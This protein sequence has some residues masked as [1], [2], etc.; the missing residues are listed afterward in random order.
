MPRRGWRGRGW[1]ELHPRRPPPGVPP[2]RCPERPAQV[3]AVPAGQERQQAKGP[4][5]ALALQD[6]DAAEVDRGWCHELQPAGSQTQLHL[7]DTLLEAKM[8]IE[9]WGVEY[10][11]LRPHSALGYRP[12]APEAWRPLEATSATLQRLPTARAPIMETL[13][14]QLVPSVGAGQKEGALDQERKLAAVVGVDV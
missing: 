7:V 13:T 2:D 6:R 3:E 1:P 12:P 5:S 9:R 14:Q 8:L 11:T 10:N 4:R